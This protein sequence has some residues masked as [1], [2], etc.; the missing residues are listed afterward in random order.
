MRH[1]IATGRAIA[2]AASLIVSASPIVSTAQAAQ[3]CDTRDKITELLQQKYKERPVALGVTTQGAL[4]EVLS[5]DA[6]ETWTIILTTP[7]GQ[8]CLVAAGEGWR[9]RT[10]VAEAP[11]A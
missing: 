7:E 11:E 4:V 3:Q 6:G 10:L 1:P 9:S 8:S 2:L 5:A